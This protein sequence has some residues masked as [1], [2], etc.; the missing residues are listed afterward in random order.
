MLTDPADPADRRHFVL[1]PDDF[2]TF[3]AMLDAPPRY[4]ARLAE[5]FNSPTVFD[6]I[7]TADRLA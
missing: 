3:T 5:L 2:D 1:S 7:I 4:N 6:P